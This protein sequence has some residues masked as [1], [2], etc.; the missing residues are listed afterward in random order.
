MNPTYIT[1]T[2][3]DGGE[4]LLAIII[5]SDWQTETEDGISFLTPPTSAMQVGV[6]QRP[7][8]YEV[9]PHIHLPVNRSLSG[10][11]EVLLVI[12]GK[13]EVTIYASDRDRVTSV[14]LLPGDMIVLLKGGHSVKFIEDSRVAE[15]KQGYYMFDKDKEYF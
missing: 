11:S 10:T 7:I 14:E 13:I 3:M 8:G 4:G 15:F 1:H 6:M 2:S 9:K 12:T 5:K